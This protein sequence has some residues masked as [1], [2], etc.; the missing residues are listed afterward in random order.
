MKITLLTHKA[1][2]DGTVTIYL[3][4]GADRKQLIDWEGLELDLE[5]HID[6][7]PRAPIDK[8]ILS[9]IHEDI[10]RVM[11]KIEGHLKTEAGANG[12]VS[13]RENIGQDPDAEASRDDVSLSNEIST[14]KAGPG[15]DPVLGRHFSAE[16]ENQEG[17]TGPGKLKESK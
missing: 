9:D 2:K 14:V 7:A 12:A 11:E 1:N 5:K 3:G 8:V 6:R 16:V 17:M 13:H 15:L 10:A 4:K